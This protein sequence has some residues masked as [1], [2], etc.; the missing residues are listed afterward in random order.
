MGLF[1]ASVLTLLLL[2]LSRFD[3]FR[4]SYTEGAEP[5]KVCQFYP[6][7]DLTP[8]TE[9]NEP[10]TNCRQVDLFCTRV[11]K[12]KP[13]NIIDP[14]NIGPPLSVP[15]GLWC[16]PPAPATE[17][18]C[19]VMTAVPLLTLSPAGDLTWGCLCTKPN[20]IVNEGSQGDCEQVIACDTGTLVHDG[21]GAP[22]REGEA[23]TLH[24]D[25][26]PSVH[27]KCNCPE[28]YKYV[29]KPDG[30]KRCLQD[31]C[32]PGTASGEGCACPENF[33][34][35]NGT[36]V[37]DPCLPGGKFVDGKCE[38]RHGFFPEPDP[39]VLFQWKCTGVCAN[40]PCGERGECFVREN[41]TFGC[42]LCKN[43]YIQNSDCKCQ[44]EACENRCPCKF[45]NQCSNNC[46]RTVFS[47]DYTCI[48]FPDICITNS[49]PVGDLDLV[50]SCKPP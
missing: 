34:E 27:G 18:T 41:N 32:F 43:G 2:W 49:A 22:D 33:V 11:T 19:N 10:C 46:C 23:W 35:T 48:P 6:P 39:N 9:E 29:A 24:K 12:D 38:C 5:K 16:L 14:H 3:R 30:D 37:S 26:D 25:W 4:L 31:A 17:S 28:G 20:L 7:S 44:G 40:N 50:Y 1:I 21:V 45:R 36:C 42:H 15:E 8:C 47:N 13:V